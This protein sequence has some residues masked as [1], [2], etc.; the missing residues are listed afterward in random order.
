MQKL[1]FLLC[2]TTALTIPSFANL[3]TNGD[4]E[5][6]DGRVGLVHSRPLNTLSGN[7]DVYNSLPGGWTTLSG[8]GIEVQ[9][10]GTVVNAHSGNLYIELDS[11]PNNTNGGSSNSSMFQAV[12]LGIGD[13]IISFYYRPRTG[14]VN[15]NGIQLRINND[16]LLNVS[17]TTGTLNSW[18]QY[19][20]NFSMAS[21]ASVNVIF[22]AI[23]TANQ[24]GG[25]IDTVSLTGGRIPPSEVPEPSTFAL[26]GASLVG[27]AIRMR[28]PLVEAGFRTKVPVD[29]H[30]LIPGRAGCFAFG[31]LDCADLLVPAWLKWPLQ[32]AIGWIRFV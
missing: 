4:F 24:L 17:E 25:F 27:I 14:T 13:Y 21:A 16:V 15:D 31:D 2:I 5:T 8:N 32:C 23:G 19:T 20:A 1:L 3:L 11:H 10:S 7:W 29:P 22:E 28:P 26:L 18:T 30:D 9:A 6:V 12:N